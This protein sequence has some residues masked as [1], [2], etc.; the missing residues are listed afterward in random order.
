MYVAKKKGADQLCDTVQLICAFV[1]AYALKAIFSHD[2]A[3]VF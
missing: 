3:Q 1:F 2:A